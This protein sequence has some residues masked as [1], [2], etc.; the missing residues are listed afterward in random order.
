M[1]K[2]DRYDLPLLDGRLDPSLDGGK[3]CFMGPQHPKQCKNSLPDMPFTKKD[4]VYLDNIKSLV[5]GTVLDGH[6]YFDT[7]DTYDN[8]CYVSKVLPPKKGHLSHMTWN[9]LL[10]DIQLTIL[11][12]LP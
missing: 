12:E 10:T 7:Y 3:D 6:Y 5:N 9:V 11:K 8:T 2:L 1:G 4:V